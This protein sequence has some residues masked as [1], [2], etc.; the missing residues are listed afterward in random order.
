MPVTAM[1]VARFRFYGELNDFLPPARRHAIFDYVFDRRASIKD[2]IEALGVPHTEPARI[3]VGGRVAG[4]GHILADRERVD[5]QP[6]TA[7][8][9]SDLRPPVPRPPRFVL[10][11]HL[12]TLARY[13][14]LFGFDSRYRNDHDDATLAA[15]S[16]R[17][18]RILL[19][20][21]RAL[22]KRGAVVH[23]RFL[24]ADEPRRQLGDVF[25]HFSL[26]DAAVPFQRCTR[27]NGLLRDVDKQ[28]IADRLEPKTRRYY[29]R[30]RQCASCGQIYWRGSHFRHLA[31]LVEEM[32]GRR[33]HAAG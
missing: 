18:G 33:F 9:G 26:A 8:R 23:G 17:E 32:T 7:S 25:I 10:D 3:E 29:R 28:H 15:I 22:L 5:V 19:T 12:G 1:A 16:A 24:R 2:V 30:F 21:D 13:L 31:G 4:F 11:T 27:C 14:R 20:R 6:G